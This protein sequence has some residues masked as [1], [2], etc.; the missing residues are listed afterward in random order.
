MDFLEQ[1]LQSN[2]SAMIIFD[3][4]CI[5]GHVFEGWFDDLESLEDQLSRKLVSCPVCDSTQAVRVP[6]TFGIKTS[7]SQYREQAPPPQLN[8]EQII[9]QLTEYV[10]KN[11]DNVGSKFTDEA[12]KIHY[13]ASEPR[14]IR[15]TSTKAQE[16]LLAKEGVN[17]VKFPMPAAP[18]NDTDA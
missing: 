9:K 8:E 5:N 2:L 4:Q 16:E 18:K 13:G 3:L 15:G 17:F 14:N 10:D 6:S 11:F 1:P 7:S 12:L